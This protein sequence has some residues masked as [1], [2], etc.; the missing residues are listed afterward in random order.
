M[1]FIFSDTIAKIGINPC[2]QVPGRVTDQLE[3]V[4]GFIYVRGKINGFAFVQTLVPVKNGPYRLYVNG[5]MLKG[6]HAQTGD[7]VKFSIEA[8]PHPEKR[9]P[10]I[11]PAFKKRLAKEKLAV[12]FK[13]LTPSRRKEILKY[14]GFL[15]TPESVERNIAKV[16]AQLKGTTK[17]PEI[18]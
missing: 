5:P 14:M 1:P 3:A 4:K 7:T 18:K 12:S 9:T 2:V 6:A 8:N 10:A 17:N 15:K 16:I 11:L 13:N